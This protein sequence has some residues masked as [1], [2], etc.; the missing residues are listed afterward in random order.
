MATTV[1]LPDQL[2]R[3]AK[4][5]AD[6][7]DRS[8]A[9]QI[10]LWARLGRAIEILIHSDAVGAQLDAAPL[11]ERLTTADSEVGR[12]RVLSYLRTLPFPH[13]EPA[14]DTPGMLIRIDADGRRTLGQFVNREFQP[15]PAW[16]TPH[17]TSD[18]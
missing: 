5:S 14:S 16:T 8:V 13:Y 12:Q 2:V 3:D 10:E 6:G 15:S 4:Q 1:E 17:S 7:T 18:Q 9:L 11:S